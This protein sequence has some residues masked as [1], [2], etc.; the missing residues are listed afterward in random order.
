MLWTEIIDIFEVQAI[1]LVPLV[2]SEGP[3]FEVFLAEF[4][5]DSIN[6]LITGMLCTYLKWR[7]LYSQQVLSVWNRN[8]RVRDD[9]STPQVLCKQIQSA[10]TFKTIHPYNRRL[11]ICDQD[12]SDN[13]AD[14]GSPSSTPDDV[15]YW[16]VTDTTTN[17]YTIG[18]YFMHSEDLF[19]SKTP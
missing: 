13:A 9:G 2:L 19:L 17:E 12:A 5:V 1:L 10:N 15:L 4:G 18:L 11:Y 8:L 16:A 7:C 6:D 3:T 14:P